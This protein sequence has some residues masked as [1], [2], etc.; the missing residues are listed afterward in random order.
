MRTILFMLTYLIFLSCS[1]QKIIVKDLDNNSDMNYI[2]SRIIPSSILK[3]ELYKGGLYVMIYQI[4]D[5]KI[6]PK[7]YFEDFLSSYFISVS[8]DGDYYSGSKLFKIEGVYNPKMI[9]IKEITYP[10]FSIKFEHG[11]AKKRKTEL[12]ELEGVQ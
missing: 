4:S 3:K 2:F 7:E 1:S 10:K 9:E 11:P 12:I 8:P 5:S 6:T